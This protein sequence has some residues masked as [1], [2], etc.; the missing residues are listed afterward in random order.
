M[1]EYLFRQKATAFKGYFNVNSFGFAAIDGEPASEN[2]VIAMEKRG[3]DMSAHKANR[4]T[5]NIVNAADYIFCMSKQIYS[6]VIVAAPDKTFLFGG[7]IDD[8]YGGD[9]AE[10]EKCADKISEEIDKLF[11]SDL[12]FSTQLIEYEDI[13]AISDIERS[14]FSDPWSENS[15]FAHISLPYSRSF[16]VKFLNKTVGYICCEHY[17]DDM[18]LLRIAVDKCV[19]RRHISERLLT[20]IIDICEYLGVLMLTLEVRESNLAAQSLYKKFGF[21]NEGKRKDFYTKPKED[22]YV[23]T[24]YFV[25]ETCLNEDNFY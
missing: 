24:K 15:F 20:M 19:R 7:G 4:I 10:Y 22:A 23:M 9:L 16:T 1:A 2:A 12:F 18:A 14:C 6:I 13:T 17:I 21:K 3:I 8:P 25:K 11:E 5:A